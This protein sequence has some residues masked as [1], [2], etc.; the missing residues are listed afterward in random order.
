MEA[1]CAAPIG[2]HARLTDGRLELAAVVA[3]PDGTATLRRTLAVALPGDRPHDGADTRLRVALRLG[4]DL[5][6][7]LLADGAAELAGLGP[8]AGR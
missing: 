6:D 2:A 3:R 4:A 5:A 8:L 7:L 1:G